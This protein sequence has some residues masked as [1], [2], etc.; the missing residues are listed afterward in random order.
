MSCTNAIKAPGS[1]F[2][3]FSNAW[4]GRPTPSHLARTIKL[5]EIAKASDNL[6]KHWKTQQKYEPNAFIA[7]HCESLAQPNQSLEH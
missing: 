3:E 6:T 5:H 7:T 2:V 1:Y 4:L